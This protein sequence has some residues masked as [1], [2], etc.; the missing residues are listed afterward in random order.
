ME[1][2]LFGLILFFGIGILLE[3]TVGYNSRYYRIFLGFVCLI[4]VVV[5]LSQ[6]PQSTVLRMIFTHIVSQD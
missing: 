6:P 1:L 3:S 4:L 5:A 2:L